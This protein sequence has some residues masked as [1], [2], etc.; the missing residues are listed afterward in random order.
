MT[1]KYEIEIPELPEGW[2]PVAYRNPKKDEWL[3]TLFG[4]L[5]QSEGAHPGLFLIVEKIKPRRI[6]LEDTGEVRKP[7]AGEYTQ[8]N[9]NFTLCRDPGLWRES[10]QIWREV[11]EEE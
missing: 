5:V 9:G 11:K 3:L 1:T 8:Y 6:V 4:G 10:Y 2:K 7:E